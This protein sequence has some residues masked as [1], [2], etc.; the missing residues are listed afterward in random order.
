MFTAF[1]DL[2]ET[3]VGFTAHGKI[4]AEDYEETLIPAVEEL[5][6]RTGRARVLLVLGPEWDGYSASA[7]FDDVKLG[8]EHRAAW[9]RFALVSDADWVH[10]VAKL[11]GWLVPGDVRSFPYPK[12]D[13]AVDWISG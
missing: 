4:R 5:I 9:E 8:L 7:M 10:L 12:L 6:E 13:E 2:P 3:A 1:P 11:F